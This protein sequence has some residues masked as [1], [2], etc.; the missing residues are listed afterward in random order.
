MSI[1]QPHDLRC[2]VPD[3]RQ[4]PGSRPITRATSDQAPSGFIG[5]GQAGYNW[6]TGAF[7]IGVETDFDGTTLSKILQLYQPRLCGHHAIPGRRLVGERQGELGL[8][9][10]DARAL[11]LRRH[12][13]Q[14]PDDLRNG[15]RRLRRRKLELHTPLTPRTTSCSSGS[16][17]SSRVGWTIGAGVEY[18]ITNN[19][20]IK[21]EYLLLQPRQHQLHVGPHRRLRHRLPGH[22]RDQQ[23]HL[24]RVDRP[25]RRELQVLS[26]SAHL[27]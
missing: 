4:L 20:T 6:Q 22:R 21:G 16:P 11:R 13:R 1:G 5:G 15:R 24:R 26:A 19:I 12:A 23:V 8:A 3:G 25:R 14:S 2:S 17:S 7:V 10:H 18:A 9:R 27:I